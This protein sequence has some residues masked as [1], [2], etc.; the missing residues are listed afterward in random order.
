MTNDNSSAQIAGDRISDDLLYSTRQ[1]AGFLG[2]S[3]RTLEAWRRQGLGPRV[4]RL[5][6][7]ALPLYRG[8]DLRAAI[9]GAP[10]AE[11][12]VQKEVQK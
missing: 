1:A 3:P 12:R 6:P 2:R 9:E 7:K 5:H 4:T 10:S 8:K 11:G